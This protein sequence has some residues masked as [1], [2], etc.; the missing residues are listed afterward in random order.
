MNPLT[1]LLFLGV[2]LSWGFIESKRCPHCRKIL[3]KK[4][5]MKLHLWYHGPEALN[6]IRQLEQGSLL[7]GL[8]CIDLCLSFQE[9]GKTFSRHD[10]VVDA[11]K[12]SLI[13]A[14]VDGGVRHG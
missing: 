2:F 6:L 8:A 4:R 12:L 3:F 5:A 14:F 9:L 13:D 7:V 1:V 11:F 10:D